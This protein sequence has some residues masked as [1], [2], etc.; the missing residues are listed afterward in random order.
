[1]L[2]QFSNIIHMR[3]NIY[4]W[5]VAWTCLGLRRRV[6]LS[7]SFCILFCQY[8]VP[9]SFKWRARPRRRFLYIYQNSKSPFWTVSLPPAHSESLYNDGK[10]IKV[11]LCFI[12]LLP[13]AKA[14]SK[15]RKNAKA[16]P[17]NRVFYIH[18]ADS[19]PQLVDLA[20]EELDKVDT[21]TYNIGNR[22]GF[23]DPDNFSLQYTINRSSDKDIPLES[24]SKYKDLIDEAV[25]LS[26]PGFKLVMQEVK[27]CY[28]VWIIK[29][30]TEMLYTLGA[31]WW[32]RW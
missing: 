10:G 17:E 8:A 11:S 31:S 19:L 28:Y 7:R 29:H 12:P 18:E 30:I 27:V 20:I 2:L 13:P 5:K 25:I 6:G 15:R 14:G 16:K 4:I 26:R 22:S 32:R 1:M 21:L 23:F 9:T 3:K 24:I